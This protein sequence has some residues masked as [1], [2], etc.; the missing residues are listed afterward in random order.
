MGVLS[1]GF[2]F[3]TVDGEK[4]QVKRGTEVVVKDGWIY[5]LVEPNLPVE[6][7]PIKATRSQDV[8]YLYWYGQIY[9]LEPFSPRVP[10]P[11]TMITPPNF[12]NKIQ[13]GIHREKVVEAAYHYFCTKLKYLRDE[14]KRIEDENVRR[15]KREELAKFCKK[16]AVFFRKNKIEWAYYEWMSKYYKWRAI[17]SK[18]VGKYKDALDKL[19]KAEEMINNALV[20]LHPKE[21]EEELRRTANYYE[22][23]R[24]EVEA[25]ICLLY[26]SPSPRD[27]G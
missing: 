27:R 18:A 24:N 7:Q 3:H 15:V 2:T 5:F 21:Y 12:A 6:E 22:A 10:Y 17:I 16:A 1:K 25:Q 23:V 13:S 19:K 4:F 20:S 26:T 9:L 8:F 14:I 11:F